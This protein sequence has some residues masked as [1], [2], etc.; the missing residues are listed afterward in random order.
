[1]VGRL[2]GG[3]SP[4]Q[5]GTEHVD[6]YTSTLSGQG[7]KQHSGAYKFVKHSPRQ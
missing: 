1:V 7:Y 6:I 3:R 5:N 4:S 2:E